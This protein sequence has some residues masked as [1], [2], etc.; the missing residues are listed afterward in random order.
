MSRRSCDL[1]DR[2]HRGAPRFAPI[3]IVIGLLTGC[4]STDRP[5]RTD[6]GTRWEQQQALVPTEDE[7]I[8]G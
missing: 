3:A 8:V 7:M 1:D 2:E 6:W 4:A 5:S